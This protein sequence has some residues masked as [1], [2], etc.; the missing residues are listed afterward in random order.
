M[1]ARHTVRFL[2][3]SNTID[4]PTYR[5][6][7]TPTRHSTKYLSLFSRRGLENTSLPFKNYSLY[8]PSHNHCTKAMPDKLRQV[9]QA[10]YVQ[11]EKLPF[12]EP[13]SRLSTFLCREN[14][15]MYSARAARG[16]HAFSRSKSFLKEQDV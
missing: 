7:H 10:L 14:R 8:F 15:R 11:T 9:L 1:H 12:V 13:R 6:K 3:W 16:C 4:L 2:W 5:Y